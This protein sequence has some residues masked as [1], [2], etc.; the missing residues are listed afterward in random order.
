VSFGDQVVFGAG[1]APVDRRRAC[2]VTRLSA[3]V[4]EESTTQRDR[5]SFLAAFSS[6]GSTSCDTHLQRQE[7]VGAPFP[8]PP[9]RASAV[10]ETGARTG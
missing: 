5:S 8:A 10:Y 9:A 4:C 1:P 6:V 3:L 2:E 7:V